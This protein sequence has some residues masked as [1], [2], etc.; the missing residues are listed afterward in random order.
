MFLPLIVCALLAVPAAAI[1]APKTPTLAQR[2]QRMEDEST[3]RRM[4]VQYGAY[5]DARD[6][7]GY[8]GLFAAQGE[9]VGGFGAFKGPAASRRCCG[10]NLEPGWTNNQ[11]SCP[12]R[13]RW[14]RLVIPESVRHWTT[15][16]AHCSPAAMSIVR[17]RVEILKRTS[18]DLSRS[19][20]NRA[21]ARLSAARP[22]T[23]RIR[24]GGAR[25]SPLIVDY[26]ATLDAHDFAAYAALFARTAPGRPARFAAGISPADARRP[27]WADACGHVNRRATT[28]FNAAVTKGDRRRAF[29]ICT[30]L[31][32]DG[33]TPTLAGLYEEF[34]AKTAE[35]LPP[36]RL[37]DHADRR[38]V[39]QGNSRAQCCGSQSQERV[40]EVGKSTAIAA[41]A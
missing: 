40:R 19:S 41:V 30:V 25:P 39:A 26:A 33:P 6:F 21:P 29:C 16:P 3:I 14:R 20:Q 10:H 31:G 34:D 5:L 11:A 32:P 17:A 36:R 24:G 38:G 28:W 23:M 13:S 7:A 15:Q 35:D 8:S 12:I 18:R 22:W 37:P 4:L 1:D 27:L 9:W 2:V